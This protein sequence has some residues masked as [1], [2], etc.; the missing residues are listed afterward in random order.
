M[1][2]L[3]PIFDGD[4]T[5][6]EAFLNSL[7]A[8]SHLNHQ[9]PAFQSYLTKIALTLTLIQ[10]LL[11]QEWTRQMGEWLDNQNA[12]LDDRRDTWDQFMRQFLASFTDTQRDQRAWNQLEILRMKWPEIDQYI[13]DF[14]RLIREAGYQTGTPKSIQMFIKGLPLSKRRVAELWN[15]TF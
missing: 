4:R 3:P 11:V 7:K 13:M 9:V 8:Y 1:G 10:G 5:K 12:I 6:A 14:E 15:Q 2:Q